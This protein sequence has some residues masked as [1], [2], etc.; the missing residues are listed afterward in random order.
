[1]SSL[2]EVESFDLLDFA[3]LWENLGKSIQDQVRWVID[4]VD[5]DV[6]PKAIEKAYDALKGINEE[7]D[8]ALGDYLDKNDEDNEDDF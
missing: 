2:Y 5:A 1:M 6:N 4:D 3:R 7:M 8:F